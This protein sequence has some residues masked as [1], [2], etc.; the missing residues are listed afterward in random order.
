MDGFCPHDKEIIR[1]AGNAYALASSSSDHNQGETILLV[2]PIFKDGTVDHDN[3]AE[4]EPQN[5]WESNFAQGMT[6]TLV[7]LAKCDW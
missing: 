5:V 6:I 3:W 1:T 4:F 2:A 7:F